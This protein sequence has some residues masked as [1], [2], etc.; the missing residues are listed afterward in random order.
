[1][2]PLQPLAEAIANAER[3]LFAPDSA[4]VA[5]VFALLAA[6][7]LWHRDE[8]AAAAHAKTWAQQLV[9]TVPQRAGSRSRRIHDAL[10]HARLRRVAAAGDVSALS[11]ATA[12]WRSW[13]AARC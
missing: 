10:T 5:D 6:H 7:A 4:A 2:T 13:R 11:P 1:M 3:A 8:A 12:L 9:S